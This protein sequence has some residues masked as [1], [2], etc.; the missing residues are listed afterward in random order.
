[1]SLASSSDKDVSLESVKQ[2]EGSDEVV[3]RLNELAGEEHKGVKIKFAAP[4][5]SAREIDGQ[6][7]TIGKAEVQNGQLNVDV[8]TYEP[9]AFAL[10]LGKGWGF[11]LGAFERSSQPS[12]QSGRN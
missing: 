5:L 9:R 4:I 10:K 7:R 6:E 12:L 8:K 3:V 1:M 2:A 11:A